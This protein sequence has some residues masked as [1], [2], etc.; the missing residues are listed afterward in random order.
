M[1]KRQKG[2]IFTL[3]FLER[4]SLIICFQNKISKLNMLIRKVLKNFLE[5]QKNIF[6]WCYYSNKTIVYISVVLPR[7]FATHFVTLLQLHSRSSGLLFSMLFIRIIFS[8][9]LIIHLG[10]KPVNP[11]PLLN[12]QVVFNF[13]FSRMML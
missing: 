6:P 11:F 3:S 4:I 5:K 7:L 2:E 8:A 13:L 1:K 10:D 9:Y 12:L